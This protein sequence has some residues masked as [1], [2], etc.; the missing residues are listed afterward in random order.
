MAHTCPVCGGVYERP[1]T[2]LVDHGDGRCCHH[3]EKSDMDLDAAFAYEFAHEVVDRRTGK[4]TM[5]QGSEK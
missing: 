3:Y 1:Q 2:C 5:R 4:R